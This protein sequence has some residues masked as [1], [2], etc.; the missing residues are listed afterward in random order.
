MNTIDDKQSQDSHVSPG[1]APAPA[2]EAV[3]RV[4]NGTPAATADPSP[5]LDA[6]TTPIEGPLHVAQPQPPVST[7]PAHRYRKWLLLAGVVAALVVG[8]HFL[9]PWVNTALNTV[10]TEDAYVNGD[11][12]FVAPRVSHPFSEMRQN[13]TNL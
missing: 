12:T 8:G 9:A 13:S 4:P 1:A 7:P 11:A 2:G 3:T 6:P 5:H 10:S